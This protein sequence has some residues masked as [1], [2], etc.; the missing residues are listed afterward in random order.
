MIEEISGFVLELFTGQNVADF[1]NSNFTAALAGALAGALMAQR[2]G[3]RAKQRDALLREIRSTNAAIMVTFTICNAGLAL[4]KQFIKD[5][6]ETYTAKK[7]AL[8]DF[9]R[10]RAAGQ[11]PPNLPFEFQADLRSLQMPVVPID[12]L[13]TQVYEN[14]SPS[15]R[16]LA[17]VAALVGAVASLS[18][19]IQK[20]NALI[21]RFQALSAEGIAQ[22]PAFYFGMPY[23]PGHVSTEFSD[24]VE[25]LHSLTDDVI[26]FSELLGTDLMA[27]GN[28]I[29][30]QY[31]SMAK[32]KKEK[33]SSVDYTEPRN[34]G[35]M[36]DATNYTDW[37]KGFPNAGQEGVP[38]YAGALRRLL[39]SFTRLR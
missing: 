9:Q 3:D 10:R 5:I 13:H 23:G 20:R 7:A 21:E 4:K 6:Y 15:G 27:H 28:R 8:K 37:L 34:Q 25:S 24:T 22:L 11:L 36:P 35:L 12:V 29:L 31:R 14:I 30:D 38:A 18:D 17:L 19:T 2:I 1:L 26:F 39:P 33:I 32:V 16:P